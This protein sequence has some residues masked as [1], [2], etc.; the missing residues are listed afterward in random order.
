M[1][2]RTPNA[3]KATDIHPD[4]CPPGPVGVAHVNGKMINMSKSTPGIV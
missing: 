4:A 2:T 3:Q 1:K